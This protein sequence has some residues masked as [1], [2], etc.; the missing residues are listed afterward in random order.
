MVVRL[1]NTAAS[2]K[3]W[4][5]LTACFFLLTN[6]SA[7]HQTFDT[8]PDQTLFF[9]TFTYL[10]GR[11]LWILD[12]MAQMWHFSESPNFVT[13]Q[14]VV[15]RIRVATWNFNLKSYLI[16]QPM[17]LKSFSF[18]FIQ[19]SVYVYG[20]LHCVLIEWNSRN[21]GHSGV[22]FVCNWGSFIE[23]WRAPDK[24]TMPITFTSVSYDSVYHLTSIE[25]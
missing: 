19:L 14:I 13:S 8:Q 18:L 15:I 4:C 23:L 1:I 11:P 5:D 6:D 7:Y 21:T 2:L 12:F 20:N 16:A 17:I 3:V 9:L 25:A 10:W 24:K 22:V